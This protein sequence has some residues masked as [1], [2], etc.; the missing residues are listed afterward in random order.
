MFSS[1]FTKY[2]LSNFDEA[3][4]SI[5]DSVEQIAEVLNSFKAWCNDIYGSI[6]YGEF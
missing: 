3:T 1:S 6:G 4:L 2:E 5:D